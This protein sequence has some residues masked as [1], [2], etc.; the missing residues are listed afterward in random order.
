MKKSG[1]GNY[2]VIESKVLYPTSYEKLSHELR[3][4][5]CGI[6]MAMGRSYGDSALSE[7]SLSPNSFD[8]VL[9]FDETRHSLTCESGVTFNE[10][11]KI[12]VPKGYFLPVVPGTKFISI[13]GAIASDI[14]GKNHH[15]AGCF[16]RYVKSF[17]LMLADG[18]ILDC[19]LSQN[20]DIFLATCGGM[21]LTG[22][23]LQ[24]SLFLKPIKSSFIQQTVI[25]IRD[26]NEL[27]EKIEEY[28]NT[29]YSVAWIDSLAKGKSLGQS[30]LILGEHEPEG[31][32]IT[33]KPSFVYF[34]KSTPCL[35]NSF[36]L[37]GLN[38][39][40]Y[41]SQFK[42]IQSQRTHYDSF[43]FP[44]DKISHW[45]N[46]YGK[47]GFLQYQ[48]VIP[49]E[50]GISPFKY[51][52]SRISSS[53]H[54]SFLSVFKKLGPKNENYLSFPMEG[55]T[56]AMDFKRTSSIFSFLEELDAVVL[57]YG[58]RSYLS[59]DARMSE[60]TFKK[61]YL[62]WEKFSFIRKQY[63]FDKSFSSL[64]SM[65]LKI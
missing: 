9:D 18:S 62:D 38:K 60:K 15:K 52:L 36:V 14:H 40:K 22:V 28:G 42:K 58:G 56:L 49:K 53:P 37:M 65:R 51:I 31:S 54:K 59:K 47:N 3:H 41:F 4:G 55:Y 7:I 11:L 25:K 5:F 21:G 27:F 13:G 19:S 45:N 57:F 30:L 34:P 6:P 32:L 35:L 61:S 10:L 12:F 24:A 26:I 44:L 2:P 46:L 29:T 63:N 8:R 39:I 50:A 23:I 43:F 16:S 48:F 33:H 1:W 20:R 17:R 64:Q